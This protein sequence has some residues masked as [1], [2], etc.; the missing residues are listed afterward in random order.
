MQSVILIF[1]DAGLDFDI[2]GKLVPHHCP[3]RYRAANSG[4]LYTP[5]LLYYIILPYLF[6]YTLDNRR[7][8]Y[9]DQ[10]LLHIHDCVASSK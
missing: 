10:T 6:P 4:N 3:V 7:T 5:A 2:H 9:I 8:A 1:H